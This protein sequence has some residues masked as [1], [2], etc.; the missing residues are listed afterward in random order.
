MKKF[1]LTLVLIAT[2][3]VALSACDMIGKPPRQESPEPPRMP[4]LTISEDGYASWGGVESLDHWVYVIN[5][6]LLH[7][8]EG[9]SLD[10]EVKTQETG[11][12]LTPGDTISVW[13]VLGEQRGV[14]ADGTYYLNADVSL[15]VYSLADRVRE[16]ASMVE[17]ML[18][19]IRSRDSL[20]RARYAAYAAACEGA[21]DNAALDALYFEHWSV[22]S[23]GELPTVEAAEYKDFFSIVPE[24]DAI[25]EHEQIYAVL[26][27][28]ELQDVKESFDA[29][30]AALEELQ[31]AYEKRV[32]VMKVCCY[33]ENTFGSESGVNLV[34]LIENGE[35]ALLGELPVSFEGYQPKHLELLND[36]GIQALDRPYLPVEDQASANLIYEGKSYQVSYNLGVFSGMGVCK[37]GDIV[38]MGEKFVLAR[39]YCSELFFDCW[40]DGSGKEINPDNFLFDYAENITLT[41]KWFADPQSFGWQFE[42]KHSFSDPDGFEVVTCFGY[43][44]CVS[45]VN[46]IPT[47]YIRRDSSRNSG[48]LEVV[49]PL[50]RDIG[51]STWRT[52]DSRQALTRYF[53]MFPDGAL[54]TSHNGNIY[55]DGYFVCVQGILTTVDGKTTLTS[56]RILKSEGTSASAGVI[57]PVFPNYTDLLAS[58]NSFTDLAGKS[59]NVT[60]RL[61]NC[62]INAEKI[63]GCY[64]VRVNGSMLNYKLSLNP[65]ILSADELAAF[66]ESLRFGEPVTLY[67]LLRYQTDK[68][69]NARLIL[70]PCLVETVH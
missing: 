25:T 32:R 28:R 37:E 42:Q 60:A 2:L 9:N 39:P 61:D 21:Q 46:G 24:M 53:S 5:V 14:S 6:G 63:D 1:L 68:A 51:S 50:I 16:K 65:S 31:S 49:N 52:F 19:K 55:L 36:G 59:E 66:E 35:G 7:D 8:E 30:K 26:T 40:V 15:D 29:Y 45:F 64:E 54:N 34:K 33:K 10:E 4:T 20:I 13:A 11:V 47:L 18:E 17:S 57:I 41:A 3:A 43:V 12:Q 44:E 67:V 38:K 22:S 58:A 23:A 56:A 69:G 27:K 70:E 48:L 62:V